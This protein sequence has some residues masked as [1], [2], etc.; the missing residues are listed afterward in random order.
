MM[1]YYLK[2]K[3]ILLIV[4]EDETDKLDSVGWTF[5]VELSTDKT[6]FHNLELQFFLNRLFDFIEPLFAPKLD[7]ICLNLLL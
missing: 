7:N 6:L 3:C 1:K 4:H 5:L 2:H